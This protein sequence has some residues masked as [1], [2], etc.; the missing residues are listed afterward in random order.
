MQGCGCSAIWSA[1]VINSWSNKVHNE[2]Q[3]RVFESWN[4]YNVRLGEG[5]G[6]TM[7]SLRDLLSALHTF[8]VQQARG[9]RLPFLLLVVLESRLMKT[10][11]RTLSTIMYLPWLKLLKIRVLFAFKAQDRVYFLILLHNQLRIYT[12]TIAL[13]LS[14]ANRPSR[15]GLS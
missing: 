5:S 8:P 13:S 7:I 15:Y 2:E 11:K 3:V 1:Q 14:R 4:S 9:E 10:E 12:L 6:S